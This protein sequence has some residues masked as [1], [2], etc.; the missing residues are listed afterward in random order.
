[1]KYN[2]G[3]ILKCYWDAGSQDESYYL[4]LVLSISERLGDESFRAMILFDND[5]SGHPWTP[6]TIDVFYASD[7]YEKVA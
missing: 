2:I 5:S 4:V 6:G 7:F 1:M 3:D